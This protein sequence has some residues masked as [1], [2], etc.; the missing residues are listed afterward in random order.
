MPHLVK[1]A[2]AMLDE[3]AWWARALKAARATETNEQ[4]EAAAA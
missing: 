3:L 4:M 2:N 1:P